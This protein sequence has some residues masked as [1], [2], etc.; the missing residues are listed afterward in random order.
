MK[1]IISILLFPSFLSILAAWG[2]FAFYKSE[3]L[4]EV[5]FASTSQGHTLRA[6]MYIAMGSGLPLAIFS[7]LTGAV[8]V[9]LS[10][11]FKSWIRAAFAFAVAASGFY[12]WHYFLTVSYP[13]C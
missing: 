12:I 1:L 10:F 2:C 4:N 7:S 3:L 8:L 6:C 9:P 11:I 13:G 5:A